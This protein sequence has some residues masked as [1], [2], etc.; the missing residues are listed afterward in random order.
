M[1][2][3]RDA[4]RRSRSPRRS[5]WGAGP[6]PFRCASDEPRPRRSPVGRR[7]AGL[8]PRPRSRR[9]A[10]STDLDSLLSPASASAWK[11]LAWRGTSSRRSGSRGP[12]PPE[13]R[14]WRCDPGEV[15]DQRERRRFG[16]LA[17]EART[18]CLAELVGA[19]QRQIDATPVSF[20]TG[21]TSRRRSRRAASP[22]TKTIDIAVGPACTGSPGAVDDGGCDVRAI[23]DRP[24][25][26]LHTD[27]TPR[28]LASEMYAA[29]SVAAVKR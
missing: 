6:A 1:R 21:R 15:T 22:M 10:D 26:A 7:P 11:V 14:S 28:R 5:R 19:H 24:Q 17:G 25:L 9:C 13:P 8:H 4:S 16:H 29:S 12:S 2:R 20:S 27:R 23:E 3:E 18:A